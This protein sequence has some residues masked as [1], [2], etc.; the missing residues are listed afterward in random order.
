MRPKDDLIVAEPAVTP[1]DEEAPPVPRRH[2]LRWFAALVILFLFFRV[3]QALASSQNMNWPTVGH[4]LFNSF[5][6]EGLLRTI[7]LTA[8]SMAIAIVI[9]VLVAIM[10]LSS[11]PVLSS[12]SWF[13]VW[14]LRAT[15]VLVQLLFW[16]F[17]AAVFPRVGIGIPYGPTWLSADTNTVIGQFTAAILGLGL[18][19][20]AY[21]AEIV[22]AG[23]LSVDEGQ[24]EAAR[25]LGMSEAQVLRKIVLPQAMR[26]IVPPTGNETISMLKMT[27]LVLVIGL[28]DLLTSS[29][30]IYS[31]NFL[32]IPLLT[33]ACFWY[34]VVTSALTIAQHFVEA[35]YGRGSAKNARRTPSLLDVGAQ[36]R[37][38]RSRPWRNLGGSRSGATV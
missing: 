5:I 3:C 35:H 6:L 28:P 11:N 10:R 9:G 26:F 19:E 13:Y 30:I 38:L 22:R 31:R 12:V 20:A 2:P 7:E 34:L 16:F 18:S 36:I 32:Q 33:V 29:E 8:I 14:F 24:S 1:S 4:Y 15:P 17:I 21:V 27:S 25:S 23:I 37:L